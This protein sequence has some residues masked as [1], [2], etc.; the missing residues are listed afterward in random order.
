MPAVLATD[1]HSKLVRIDDALGGNPIRFT[2]AWAPGSLSPASA[3]N[4]GGF[5]DGV[6]F[7]WKDLSRVADDHARSRL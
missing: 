2:W 6:M 1:C 7:A 3:P 4:G 5:L